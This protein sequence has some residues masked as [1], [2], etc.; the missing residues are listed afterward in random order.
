MSG[1]SAEALTKA[2]EYDFYNLADKYDLKMNRILIIK[3]ITV[4]LLLTV[5]ATAQRKKKKKTD[6]LSVYREYAQLG[7][8][9]QGVPLQMNVHFVYKAVPAIS[10]Q[11]STEADMLLYYGSNEFYLQTENMEQIVNDSL[12]VMVNNEAKMIK[13]FPNNGETMQNLEKMGAVP[14]AD[15]SLQKIVARYSG[16]M[17][18]E[19]KNTKRI[20]LQSREKIFGTELFKETISIIYQSETYKPLVY[21]HSKLSL[22]PVDTTVYSQLT[23]DPAY[24][25][26]LVNTKTEAGNLFFIVKEKITQYR[27]ININHEQ[28]TPPAR[29][30]DRVVKTENGEYK[31]ARGFEEYLVSR[32]W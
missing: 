16:I 10:A 23:N 13:L 27:F 1:V 15:S 4:L 9:Y 11:D 24:T 17:R 8:W 5:S 19:G 14:V 31:P 20:T 2:D 21:N 3:L 28:K 12:V 26:R 18:E 32:E 30:Q 25:G 29:E 7:R 6:T 22:F